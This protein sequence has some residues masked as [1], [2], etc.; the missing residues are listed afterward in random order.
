MA[1]RIALEALDFDHLGAELRE[2]HRTVRARDVTGEVEHGDAV[3]RRFFS[4]AQICFLRRVAR[5][6]SKPL[7]RRALVAVFRRRPG[8]FAGSV[9]EEHRQSHL[10]HAAESRIVDLLAHIERARLR[11]IDEFLARHHR[12]AWNVGLAQ[13]AQ[14]LVARARADDRLDDV[15]ERLPVLAGDSPRRIFETRIADQVGPIDRDGELAPEGRVAA[16]GEQVLAV[17]GLEQTINRNRAERILR[18][19]IEGRHFFV[20]QDS[21]GV[22]RES[23]GQKRDFDRLPCSVRTAREERRD[24]RCRRHHARRITRSGKHQRDRIAAARPLTAGDS[25]ARRDEV[26]VGVEVGVGTAAAER[27]HAERNRAR[28]YAVNRFGVESKLLQP[29]GCEAG[30]DDVS[31][32]NQLRDARLRCAI[33]EVQLERA[34]GAVEDVEVR[35][36]ALART[37]R[38]LDLDCTRAVFRQQHRGVSCAEVG[39]EFNDVDRVECFTHLNNCR[40][41]FWEL[42]CRRGPPRKA[43]DRANAL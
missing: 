23:A 42:N 30:D 10:N 31:P 40:A 9:V 19:V 1:K 5:W 33:V 16:C 27:R 38:W 7:Q 13:D 11:M 4:D 24:R 29:R 21:A 26:V 17:G 41:P 18:A 37:A 2:D 36:A 25:T 12:R 34:L 6:L 28:I 35:R 15:L 43:N 8:D 3:E 39:V 32:S 14:P 22:E 20:P